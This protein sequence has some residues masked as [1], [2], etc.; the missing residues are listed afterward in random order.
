M[1]QAGA[2]STSEGNGPKVMKGLKDAGVI[3][4]NIFGFMLTLAAQQSYLDIGGYTTTD[5]R[6]PGYLKWYS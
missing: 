6:D 4:E 2:S 3:T 5:F 1:S